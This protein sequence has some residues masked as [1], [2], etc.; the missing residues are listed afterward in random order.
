MKNIG[1]KISVIICILLL[2]FLL[3]WGCLNQLQ[4]V[5]QK[6][7]YI[8]GISTG[9]SLKINAREVAKISFEEAKGEAEKEGYSFA[10]NSRAGII[11]YI[12]SIQEPNLSYNALTITIWYNSSTN[13]TWLEA[14]YLLENPFPQ[15][16]LKEKE[17]YVKDSVNEI[18]DICGLTIDWSEAK[19]T[20]S[21]VD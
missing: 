1:F 11:S 7:K 21:Y 8:D 14:D 18:A 12:A 9:K 13:E 10:N 3:I 2:S 20:I 15:S 4:N 6:E 5:S 17:Q 16:N 19:W